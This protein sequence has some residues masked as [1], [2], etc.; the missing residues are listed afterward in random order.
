MPLGV[1]LCFAVKRM[2]E[3]ERWAAFVREDLGLD[4]V[5]FTFD[6]LDPTSSVP[7]WPVGCATP[8]RPTT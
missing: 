3:P 1:N 4:R 6:L 7:A 2:P 8:L 5:Q